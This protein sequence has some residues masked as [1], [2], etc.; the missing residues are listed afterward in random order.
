MPE[1]SKK[2]N[3]NLPHASNYLHSTYTVLGTI[4]NLEMI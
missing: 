2:K 4:I 3:L 1:T